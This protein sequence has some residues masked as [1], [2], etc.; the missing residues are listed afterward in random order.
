MLNFPQILWASKTEGERGTDAGSD[1]GATS[2]YID[3]LHQ[4][5]EKYHRQIPDFTPEQMREIL[6]KDPKGMLTLHL[7]LKFS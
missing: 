2:E 6:F 1:G 7:D 3:S 4:I 5:V